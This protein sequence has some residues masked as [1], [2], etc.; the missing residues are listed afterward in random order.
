M[1]QPRLILVTRR[2]WPLVGGAEIVMGRLAAAFQAR[3]LATTVLTARW[4]SDWPVEIEHHGVRVVRLSNPAHRVWGTWRYMQSLAR[5]LRRHGGEFDLVYASMLK[6]DAYAA[7]GEGGRAGFPVAIR[8]EGAGLTGD[9][10]WQLDAHCGLRIKR[11]LMAADALI[12]PS[13]AIQRELIAA[14]YPRDRIHYLPNGVALPAERDEAARREARESLAEVDP[15][16]AP[17]PEAPLVLYTGR[18]HEMKGLDYLVSAWPAVLA[19]NPLARLWLVGEGAYRKELTALIHDL[20]LGGQVHLA[21]AFDDVE[22]FLL[23]A[24]LFVLPSL[25][26]GMSLSLL[27]AMALGLPVV[28][29]SI[30]ANQVLVDDDRNGRLVPP[31][32]PAALAAAINELLAHA[33]AARRLGDEARQRVGADFS[34]DKMVADHLALFDRLAAGPDYSWSPH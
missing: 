18:L 10:Q 11:R 7:L 32:D 33:D 12:A 1:S 31:A 23:A 27:E 16:L 21:G 13:P 22:D 28:A 24:D 8:A 4:Q 25:E 34:S 19:R 15:A 29:T 3:G 2:F 26:E 14:G 17:A 5:W 20:G 30:P 9:C 6:H